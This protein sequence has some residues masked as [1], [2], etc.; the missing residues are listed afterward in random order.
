MKIGFFPNLGKANIID[1][2]QRTAELCAQHELE[3]FIPDDLT[4]KPVQEELHIDDSHVLPRKELFSI[5]DMAFSFGGDGTIIHLARQL[6]SYRVPVCGI[7]LGELGFLNQVDLSQLETAIE[8]IATGNYRLEERSYLTGCIL[9]ADGSS[10]EL[11]PAMNDIHVTH[12]IPGKMARITLAI[13]GGRTQQYPAD[14]L[15][16]STS[17]GSTGYNL[18][19]GGPIM[20]PDNH[21]IIVTPV[22]PHLLQNVS[23]ILKES[24]RIDITMPEREKE[25]HISVDGTF[26]YTFTNRDTLHVES[27]KKYSLFVRFY[28]QKFFGTLF[29]KLSARREQLP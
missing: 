27:A 29:G 14:G 6:L 8:R 5:L 7:N 9:T 10:Q 24:G 20:A 26:G 15:L 23:L 22:C 19:A 11:E 3:V 28:D 18:S 1:I 13:N 17:T 4:E 25:L 2:M 12:T 16:I 21:S